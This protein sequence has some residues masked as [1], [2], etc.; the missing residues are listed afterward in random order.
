V[1]KL[2]LGCV[3]IAFLLAG[4]SSRA[5]SA[6]GEEC[7]NQ[8]QSD[9]DDCHIR[10]GDDPADADDLA[11]CIQNARDDYRSCTENCADQAD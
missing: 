10:L 7:D 9:V 8:Y 5:G 4:W 1:H 6:C 3:V 2:L 11:R